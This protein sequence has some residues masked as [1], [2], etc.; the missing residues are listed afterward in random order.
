[1]TEQFIAALEAQSIPFAM[2][3]GSRRER[4]EQSRLLIE[5]FAP[6]LNFAD[7]LG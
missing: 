6:P 1:M 7:P 5:K 4:L 2:I 3:D